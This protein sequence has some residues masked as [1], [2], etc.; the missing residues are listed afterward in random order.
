MNSDALAIPSILL[1]MLRHRA[2]ITINLLPPQHHVCLLSVG[3]VRDPA[4]GRPRRRLL[5]HLIH[6]LQTQ[7]L[8]LRHTQVRKHKAETAG[9]AP[10]EEHLGLQ[11]PSIL[12]HHVRRDEA[13]DTVP[14]PVTCRR[15][16][17]ALCSDRQREQL[18]DHHPCG[19][20]PG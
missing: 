20:S 12:V 11:I 6:L 9:S 3:R 4:L 15:E 14:E 17:H 13:D 8:R 18:A 10:D 2:G 1:S 5:Q 7:P 19:G 16:R